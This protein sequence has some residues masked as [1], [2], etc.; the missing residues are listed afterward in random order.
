M[1]FAH[2][3]TTN[4]GIGHDQGLHDQPPYTTTTTTALLSLTLIRASLK[5]PANGDMA[6]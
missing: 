2:N 4:D 1:R 5:Y 6:C 3:L